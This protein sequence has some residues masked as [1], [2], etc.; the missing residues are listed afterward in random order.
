MVSVEA[1]KT[2]VS[3]LQ[4]SFLLSLRKACTLI[5]LS[6]SVYQYQAKQRNDEPIIQG[7]LD[8]VERY[9]RFG[10]AKYF[11]LLR[12]QGHVW[13]HKRVHRVYCQLGLNLK[14][15]TKKRLPTRLAI[16]L[17][18]PAS[19][20][21]SWSMDFMSDC[22]YDG[23]R[24]RT[25][26]VLD[27]FNREI[28]A[29]EADRSLP[30]QRVTRVLDQIVAWRGYPNSIRVDNGPEF[31]SATLLEWA[32]KHQVELKFIQPG[33]PT[34]NAYIERFNRSFRTEVLSYYVFDT[35]TQVR[36]VAHKWMI[37]YNEERPHESLQNLTPIQYL[38]DH[39]IQQNTTF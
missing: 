6:R 2:I 5:G 10:F 3:Y 13:N 24:F 37:Q 22:L 21:Q 8:L 14:R 17:E 4:E 18:V 35:L 33:K 30:A 34:Q 31:I 9:P 23:R 29:I 27:D 26:N 39:Q 32:E 36:E 11:V 28:L 1:K 16:P 25:L 19:V 12:N 7:L 20:N 38:T 15:R